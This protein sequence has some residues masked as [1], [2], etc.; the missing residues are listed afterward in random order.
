MCV[1][2]NKWRTPHATV[3][4]SPPL[5]ALFSHP[6]PPFRGGR[7]WPATFFAH[8]PP[9]SRRPVAGTTPVS[10]EEEGGRAPGEQQGSSDLVC[11]GHPR[12]ARGRG[13]GG[14]VHGRNGRGGRAAPRSLLPLAR[15]TPP[16]EAPPHG[17]QRDMMSLTQ[18]PPP[19]SLTQPP[20]PHR[21]ALLRPNREVVC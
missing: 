20:P 6:L 18:P 14:A 7:A 15:V 11:L 13:T 19:M 16:A 9:P 1:N 8:H 12:P 4:Q 5:Y 17:H 2:V 21:V 10:G 3:S